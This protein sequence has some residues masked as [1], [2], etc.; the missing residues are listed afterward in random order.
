MKPKQVTENFEFEQTT[1]RRMMAAL[2]AAGMAGLAGCTGG[3]NGNSSGNG[4]G[5]GNNNASQKENVQIR[6]IPHGNP[7]ADPF[8]EAQKQGWNLAVDQLGVQAAFQPPNE[9]GSFTQQV[10][11]IEAAVAAGVD[12]IAVT[13]PNPSLYKEALKSANKKNIFVIVTNIVE[14][15]FLKK[16][17]QSMPYH[18]YIGQNEAVVGEQ[19][20]TDAIP[21]FKKAEGSPPSR[22]VVLN[23]N[24]GNKALKLRQKGILRVLR[25]QNIPHD[26]IEI[27]AG[28]PSGVISQLS[29]YLASHSKTDLVF[30]L[31]PVGGNPTVQY[32]NDEGL[33]GKLYHAGVDLSKQLAK[34]IRKGYNLA[35]VIQQPALQGYLAALFLTGHKRWGFLTPTHI[36]TGPTLVTN[37]NL[38]TVKEQVKTFGV[39]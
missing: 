32:I 3:G 37:D 6:Y 4:S 34:A 9:S 22:A 26:W 35:Q 38:D 13:L 2:G 36:P 27:P 11:N 7:V 25:K 10:S 16:G 19:L 31:G 18:G 39:A 29:S 33:Q 15:S 5:T 23:Q 21:L 30:T 8:W 28:D 17:E 24:P 1:R 20:A 12:G 14:Q